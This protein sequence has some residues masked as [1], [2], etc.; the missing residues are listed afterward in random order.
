MASKQLKGKCEICS[1][2]IP[3]NMITR[4][5]DKCLGTE[6]QEM[7]VLEIRAAAPGLPYWMEFDI[8]EA[9]TLTDLDDFLRVM[10][11]ECCSHLSAFHIGA[12]SYTRAPMVFGFRGFQPERAM[13][14]KLRPLLTPGTRFGYE[15]DFG[16][17]TQLVLEVIARRLVSSRKH[18]VRLLAINEDPVWP[19]LECGASAVSLCSECQYETDAFFCARHARS[20]ACGE[21]MLLPVVNSPRMGVCGY[22]GGADYEWELEPSLTE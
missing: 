20:H 2:T 22:T 16:S 12:T 1:T 5:F 13:T 10:W 14:V 7:A 11:V 19:C 21:E 9:A 15:Y 8:N 18:P 17:T 3:K 4:H 6:R